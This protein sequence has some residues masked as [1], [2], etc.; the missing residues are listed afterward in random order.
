M[1]RG[2]GRRR[3]I[4][5][6]SKVLWTLLILCVYRLLCHIPLPFVSADYMKTMVGENGSLGLWNVL[7]GGGL[8]SM[9]LM[10]LG[11]TPYITASI[12][13]QLLGVVFPRLADLQK[14]GST[15]RK[16]MEQ[17]TIAVAA[18]LA[19]FQS[20]FMMI[21]YGRQ[22]LLSSLTWYTVLIP[23][24]LMT[25]GVFLISFAG[26]FIT[27]HLFGNGIS[28]ILLTGIL[29]SYFSD[30]QALGSVLTA[31]KNLPLAVLSCVG[32]LLA[33]VLLFVFTI[34]LNSC[35]K[36]ITVIYSGK[37]QMHAGYC[38]QNVIPLK[39]IA[40]SVV[41]IIFA[42]TI[43]TIPALIQSFTGTDVK[44]L[45]I[46]N[47]SHWFSLSEPWASM[48]VVLYCLMIVGFSYYYNALN[49]NER[50]IADT[51]KRQGGTISGI[52]PGKPTEE[53]LRR[54]MRYLTLLGSLGL[55][56]IALVP[57]ILTAVLGI[58]NLSFF[59]TSIIITVSVI[60]E[61]KKSFQAERTASPYV[62]NTMFLGQQSASSFLR[63]KGVKS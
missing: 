5:F 16:K 6:R 27:E 1:F 42:S 10:A 30:A 31:N 56:V 55:C 3:M 7:T 23:S 26:Q 43:I 24:V 8:E 38:P 25:L 9:S 33:V 61:T 41:P 13:L 18:G 37:M 51:L 44:W 34:W 19:L 17:V 2:Y 20:V 62:K 48:G 47:S 53:Y 22:G 12:V 15:G 4:S 49:L 40:G 63:R 57:M 32:M 29:A 50:Q 36:K 58:S 14:E 21:G 52:R 60:A 11:I 28:L 59:G 39:L 54:Q 45:W 35:E 46:F